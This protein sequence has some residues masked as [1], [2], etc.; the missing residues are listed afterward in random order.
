MNTNHEDTGVTVAL[1][2][3]GNTVHLDVSTIAGTVGIK[4]DDTKSVYTA[5]HEAK[6]DIARLVSDSID[7]AIATWLVSQS[8]DK[9]IAW[10]EPAED[11]PIQIVTPA[12]AAAVLD[13]K[14]V[15]TPA[16]QPVLEMPDFGDIDA[17]HAEALAEDA[18][19]DDDDEPPTKTEAPKAKRARKAKD[20]VP[21][22]AA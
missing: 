17:L 9:A 13:G 12:D 2:K 7:K 18:L 5:M 20:S 1:R 16:A 22:D 8:I 10:R 19:R 3:T 14:Q 4:L 11:F 21:P 6:D 15:A